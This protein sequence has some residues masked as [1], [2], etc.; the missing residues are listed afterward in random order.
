MTTTL[1]EPPEHSQTSPAD[2]LRSCAAAM[3]I[4]FTWFGVRKTLTPPQ[5]HSRTT[6][7]CSV[8]DLVIDTGG[9]V[10]CLYSEMIDL[11]AL[12]KLTIR[13]ASHVEP[14][15]QGNWWADMAPVHG[16]RLG[17]FR[18]PS[19]ALT[20]ER[21]WLATQLVGADGEERSSRPHA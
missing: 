3:R 9:N 1:E 14:D 19:E 18:N 20:A 6:G 8:M 12:G 4:S 21:D 13:R 10:R 15:E 7:R 17:P 2:H 16:P 5:D 11:A